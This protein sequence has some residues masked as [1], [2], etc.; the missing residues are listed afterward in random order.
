MRSTQIQLSRV[1]VPRREGS[2]P[3]IQLAKG[4]ILVVDNVWH[5]EIARTSGSITLKPLNSDVART[6]TGQE[7]RDL[8]FDPERSVRILRKAVSTLSPSTTDAISRAFESF[9]DE[10]QAEMLRRLDYVRACDRFFSRK[11]FSKRPKAGYARIA[12]VV[13]C[14]RQKVEASATNKRPLE[15]G[16]D[17]VGGSTLRRWYTI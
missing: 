11:A 12:K 6:L 13:A 7:L 4:D 1:H 16:R 9:T 2:V 8:Y 10:Q 3:L 5:E 15:V 17:Y 14:Y